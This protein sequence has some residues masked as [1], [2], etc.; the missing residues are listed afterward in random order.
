M[1]RDDLWLIRVAESVREELRIKKPGTSLR[2]RPVKKPQESNTGGWMV[3]IGRVG[4]CWLDIWLDRYS[5]K[6]FRTFYAGFYSADDIFLQQLVKTSR[7]DWPVVFSLS[8]GDV[9]RGKFQH[10]KKPLKTKLFNA[11][12]VENYR[13]D[14]SNHF[15]GFYDR[16]GGEPER[17]ERRFIRQASAFFLDVLHRMP[18]ARNPTTGDEEVYPRIENRLLVR[19]HLVR[20]R[21]RYLAAQC[22][23]RDSYLC[24]ICG[25][26]FETFYGAL[27][28]QF[29]EAHHKKAL[30]SLKGKATTDLKD[31]ITVCANCHRML[32]R[33][34]GGP[35][36]VLKLRTKMRL[37][38]ARRQ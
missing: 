22:K 5:L 19:S 7:R 36:D 16:M 3:S 8:D 15:F 38:R 18:E 6:P 35:A 23:E 2:L 17:I 13:E 33:M 31:L 11:P 21:S 34:D 32:H 30:A 29:A 1:K 4:P 14:G 25:F 9:S 20:E 10:L 28:S 24:Q 37:Q 27:G 12:V 26:D